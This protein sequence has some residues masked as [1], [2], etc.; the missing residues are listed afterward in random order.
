LSYAPGLEEVFLNG[1][2][3]TRDVD[4]FASSGT[5]I[6]S[7][8]PLTAGDKATV[9]GWTPFV[10]ADKIT[11]SDV[12]E[13]A[14]ISYSKLNL[15]DSITDSDVA[16]NAAIESNKLS[17]QSAGSNAEIRTVQSKLSDFVSVKDFGALGDGSDATQAIQAALD[18]AASAVFLGGAIYFPAGTYRVTSTIKVKR[19]RTL[20]Y[21]SGTSSRINFVPTEHDQVCF[22]FLKDDKSP[23]NQC[24][25]RDL[26][27]FSTDTTY[28]K[29]CLKLVDISLCSFYNIQTLSPH[30]S[31]SSGQSNFLWILGRDQ[32]TIIQTLIYADKPIRISPIPE[33]HSG[34][35]IGIDHFNFHGMTLAALAENPLVTIDSGVN[36]TQV[37]FTGYQAW[38]RGTHG[39]YWVDTETIGVSNGLYLE[40][41]RREGTPYLN[42][43]LVYIDHNYGLQGLVVR[44]GQAGGI[45][46]FYLRKVQKVSIENYWLTSV[47]VEAL[48]TNN[49]SSITI[50]NCFWQSGQTISIPDQK[51]VYNLPYASGFPLPSTAYY[52]NSSS[53]EASQLVRFPGGINAV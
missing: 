1:V 36:L 18:A 2:L 11:D 46:G 38:I 53:A 43:H 37:S 48:N 35:I 9:L 42:N 4:Y 40:N 23:I 34:L 22:E 52:V 12:A 31:D 28:R 14:D 29:V 19:D 50:Q 24:Q 7:L 44:N 3:L 41:V 16:A 47:G 30:W 21:G 10:V 45:G 5:S 15:S 49:V 32:T 39:I 13:D 8:S 6:T 33:G 17:F 26:A 27:F 51:L 20:I 25:M